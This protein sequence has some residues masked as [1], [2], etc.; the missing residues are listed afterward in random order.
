MTRLTKYNACRQLIT[1][2]HSTIA[3]TNGLD[4]TVVVTQGGKSEKFGKFNRQ[5]IAIGT[6]KLVDIVTR[7][8]V[9]KIAQVNSGQ[10]LRVSGDRNV[11]T[12]DAEPF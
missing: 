6:K 10:P 12:I 9:R 5:D 3:T 4:H 8:L 11:K 1:V 7:D 2:P